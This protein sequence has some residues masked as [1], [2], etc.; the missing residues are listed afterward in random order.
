MLL[1]SGA[2]CDSD[3]SYAGSAWVQPWTTKNWGGGDMRA[4]H[5]WW[6]EHIPNTT[7]ET[8][9]ISNNW[10]EYMVDPNKV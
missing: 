1:T 8:D 6:Y 2:D 3:N 10:W 7:G 9:G 4:H 5:L